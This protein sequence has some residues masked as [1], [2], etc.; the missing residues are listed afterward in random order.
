MTGLRTIDGVS[1][2]VIKEK[3]EAIYYEHLCRNLQ[4]F[5]K[6]GQIKLDKNIIYITKQ[7]KFVGDSIASDLFFIH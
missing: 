4:K 2:T 7:G 6:N 1:L 3:F 5:L